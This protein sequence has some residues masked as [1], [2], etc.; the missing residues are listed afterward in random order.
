MLYFLLRR[1]RCAR[2]FV[3]RNN[4]GLSK[5][6]AAGYP[7]NGTLL[8]QYFINFTARGGVKNL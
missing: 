1:A 5:T 3:H 8:H 6:S 7:V 4:I 2:F